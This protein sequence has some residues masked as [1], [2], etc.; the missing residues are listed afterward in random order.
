MINGCHDGQQ[1]EKKPQEKVHL[2]TDSRIDCEPLWI[3]IVTCKSVEFH[4]ALYNM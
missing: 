1:I 3:A 2:N 4:C